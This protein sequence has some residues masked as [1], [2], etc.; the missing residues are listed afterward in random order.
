MSLRMRFLRHIFLTAALLLL[1]AI[2]AQNQP[3]T[4]PGPADEATPQNT[5]QQ[6]HDLSTQAVAAI[7][8]TPRPAPPTPH[9]VEHLVDSALELFHVQPSGNTAM[10]YV[11]AGLFLVLAVLLRR[12]VTAL[13]FGV[14]KK[15]AT[16]AVP[17]LNERLFPALEAPASALIVVTGALAALKALKLSEASHG[18]LDYAAAIAYSLALLWLALRAVNAILDHLQDAARE[19]Q[20]GVAAFMPWIKKALLSLVVVFGALKI[21]QSFGADVGAFLAGLGLGGLAFALAAQDTIANLFG[22]VVVAIDQPFKLGEMVK[23]GAQQGTVE[24]IGLRSTKIRLLDRSLAVIPNKSVA[25]EPIINLS[26]FTSH[27]TEQVIG[28]T[29]DTTPEQMEKIVEDIRALIRADPQVNAAS[30][31]VFFRDYAASSL[32][33]WLA[34]VTRDPDMNAHFATK[35]RINLAI[36]RAVAARGLTFAFPTSVMHLDGPVAK[37][38]AERK[39]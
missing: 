12:A 31:Q 33:L 20:M 23:I 18:R 6:E 30:V 21:A 38:I 9:F 26:R 14:L 27:R 4:P 34:Y 7:Q 19:K 17:T 22:S 28:L 39:G 29:Y 13:V 36:M 10:R 2:H 15:R 8:L 25:A 11:I 16:H 5:T 3:A 24:D 37:Q 1:P 32:D 35:Q